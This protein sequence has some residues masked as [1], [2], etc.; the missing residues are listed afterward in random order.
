M[1]YYS[2]LRYPGGK[3][4]LARPIAAMCEEHGIDGHYVEPYAGGAAVGLYLLLNK[5]VKKITINDIDRSIYAFWHTIVNKPDMLCDWIKRTPITIK[6]WNIEKR[7]QVNKSESELFKLGCSTFFL[8]RVNYSGII[9][10]GVLGGIE[11]TSNYKMDC[12]FNKDMLISRIYQ[13]AEFKKN[14]HVCNLD[15][16]KLIKHVKDKFGH[17]N[18]LYYFDPPYY[19]KG[20][21]LYTNYYKD[22]D[23]VDMCNNIR[24][25]KTAYWI[26][27]YDD[28]RV[29][30]RYYDGYETYRYSVYHNANNMQKGREVLFFSKNFKNTTN[31]VCK[32]LTDSVCA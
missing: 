20:S 22:A 7:I 6:K 10:G 3:K 31:L 13:I 32:Y 11:Q 16:E 26:V 21:S 28:E 15:A 12:R 23:H 27:S 2:P 30:R 25:I 4:R 19:K 29:I 9:D 18:T 1:R 14:I 5:Y 8:N 24:G 17:K